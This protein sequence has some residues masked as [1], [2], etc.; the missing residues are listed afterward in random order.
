MAGGFGMF[1]LRELVES[2]GGRFHVLSAPGKGSRITLIIPTAQR[3]AASAPGIP[4]PKSNGKK[5]NGA[6]IPTRFNSVQKMPV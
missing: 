1:S 2:L 4:Q 5:A 3:A 6:S